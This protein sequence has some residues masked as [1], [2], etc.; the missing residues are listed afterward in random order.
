MEVLR[1]VV[2]WPGW[3]CFGHTVPLCPGDRTAPPTCS[4][5]IRALCL[6]FDREC[7]DD[8]RVTWRWLPRLSKSRILSCDS[9]AADDRVMR[10]ASPQG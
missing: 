7:S 10:S 1:V 4:A 3:M 2:A 9:A 5:R 6:L 8:T